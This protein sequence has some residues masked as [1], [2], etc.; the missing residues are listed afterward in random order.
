MSLRWSFAAAGV[1]DLVGYDLNGGGAPCPR[2][3]W[4]V[5]CSRGLKPLPPPSRR[6]TGGAPIREIDRSRPRLKTDQSHFGGPRSHW[7]DR[8]LALCSLVHCFSV[9]RY[10]P[11]TP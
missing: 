3:E 6:S 10:P 7:A 4:A 8:A 9:L 5:A 11:P 1:A 2:L